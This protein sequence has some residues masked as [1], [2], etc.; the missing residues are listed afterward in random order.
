MNRFYFYG[1]LLAIFLSQLTACNTSPKE[2]ESNFSQ[3][4]SFALAKPLIRTGETLFKDSAEI[5]MQLGMEGVNI[6][7]TMDG[8]SPNEKSPQYEGPFSVQEA[9][10]L[11]AIAIAPSWMD[12]EVSAIEFVK[13]GR[14]AQSANLKGDPSASYPGEGAASLI[15]GKKGSLDFRDGKWLGY[16]GTDL[17]AEIDLGEIV[18][19]EIVSVSSLEDAGSW[20]FFPSFI[21]VLGSQDGNSFSPLTST[22]IGSLPEGAA[23]ELQYFR[24]NFEPTSLRYLR[25]FIKNRGELPSWHPGAES[26]GKPWLF[27]DEVLFE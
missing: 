11:K 16:E 10:V 14:K 24:M 12:S 17:E 3:T 8:S 21:E 22:E 2:E 27:V 6:Y 4:G 9:C 26:G 13:I 18:E 1:L 5:E 25:V 20:I 15:D 23:G 7:Y 19:L